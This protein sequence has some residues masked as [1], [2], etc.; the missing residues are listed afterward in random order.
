MTALLASILKFFVETVPGRLI[1]AA[2]ALWLWTSYQRHDAAQ[3]ARAECQEATLRATEKE[4]RR[5]L[6]AAQD[7]AQ[8]AQEQ[9]SKSNREMAA[10]QRDLESINATDK[11]ED[12]QGQPAPCGVPDAKRRRLQ[13][14]R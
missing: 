7:A 5:Q 6:Q 9:A 3:E 13:N 11:T 8:Q 1:L 12:K 4:L 2:V 14:I 10:L